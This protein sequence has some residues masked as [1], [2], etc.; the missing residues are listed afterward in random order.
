MTCDTN[1]AR[2]TSDNYRSYRWL[3][4]YGEE[5]LTTDLWTLYFMLLENDGK[6]AVLLVHRAKLMSFVEIL[7]A[8]YFGRR[9]ARRAGWPQSTHERALLAW[10]LY[11]VDP[12]R[13]YPPLYLYC[14][15]SSWIWFII[16]HDMLSN[17]DSRRLH[18]SRGLLQDE[19]LHAR[20]CPRLL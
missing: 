4:D 19:N 11:A 7:C 20:L 6:N 14:L 3:D 2:T 16:Y 10:I 17:I 8:L 15:P 1:N 18:G 12:M 5:D 13:E 9:L